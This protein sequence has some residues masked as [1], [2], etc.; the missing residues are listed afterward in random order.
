MEVLKMCSGLDVSKS[1]FHAN[2]VLLLKDQRL[3][4]IRSRVFGNNKKGIKEYLEWVRKPQSNYAIPLVHVMESTGVY[5]ELLAFSLFKSGHVVS[6]VLPNKAKKYI[7]ALGIKTKNDKSD[8]KALAFMG[9]QQVLEPWEPMGDFF[10]QL[11]VLTRMYQAYTENITAL[12]NQI[13]ALSHGMHRYSEVVKDIQSVIR[14]YK[15]LCAKMLKQ[16]Q[17]HLASDSLIQK[18]VTNICKIKGVST[19]TIAVILA[20]TN[21]FLL[22][23]NSRQ[24][25]SYSG[26]DVVENQSGKHIGKTKISKKGSGRIRRALFMPAFTVVQKDKRFMEFYERIYERTRIKMKAYVAVQKKLLVVIYGLWKNKQAYS[27]N[28]LENNTTREFEPAHPSR[29]VLLEKSSVAQGNATQGIQPE[30][31]H[32]LHPLGKYKISEKN[33]HM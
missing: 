17:E 26:Y 31:N 14:R 21:G 32:R 27:P 9:A 5:H 12:N 8:A 19:L 25:V 16:I 3:K 18:R 30:K 6:V 4:V 10:Y 15:T 22:F 11:R 28:Y 24:L 29:Y 23:K 7:A 33:L 2:L 13:E 1:E 20:E